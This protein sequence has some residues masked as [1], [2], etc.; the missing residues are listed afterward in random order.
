MRR[1]TEVCGVMKTATLME[2]MAAVNSSSIWLFRLSSESVHSQ[3]VSHELSLH[4]HAHAILESLLSTDNA[5][6][7]QFQR[8]L[9]K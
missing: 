4:I 1:L 6:H 3:N 9:Q 7:L 5:F 8:R 2:L